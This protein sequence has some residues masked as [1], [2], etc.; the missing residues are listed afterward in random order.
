MRARQLHETGVRARSQVGAKTGSPSAI[1]DASKALALA[2]ERRIGVVEA[3]A[4]LALAS[5][6]APMGEFEECE[7][8][9]CCALT[10]FEE[11]GSVWGQAQC[12]LLQVELA[13]AF[14]RLISC[15]S[16]G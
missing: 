11:A 14:I 10:L 16:G 8:E 4:L 2:R 6:R 3:L 12:L 9:A 15:L 13:C 1:A 7:R 5:A